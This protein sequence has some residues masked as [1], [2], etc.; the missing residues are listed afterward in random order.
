MNAAP[1]HGDGGYPGQRHQPFAMPGAA[2]ADSHGQ[3]KRTAGEAA[4]VDFVELFDDKVENLT[5]F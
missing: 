3:R 5:T 2:K 1:A 4:R